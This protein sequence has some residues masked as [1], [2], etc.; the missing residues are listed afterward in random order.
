[1]I[2]GT[3][4][5]TPFKDDDEISIDFGKIKNFFKPETG[6]DK[7]PHDDI[8]TLGQICSVLQKIWVIF[9]ALITILLSIYIRRKQYTCRLL[10]NGLRTA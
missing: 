8:N 9:L 7:M 5:K 10:M 3:K 6:T 2:L 4:Q 1:M